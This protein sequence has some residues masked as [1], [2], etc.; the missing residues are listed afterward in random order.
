MKDQKKKENALEEILQKSAVLERLPMEAIF[1]P[2]TMNRLTKAFGY[3]DEDEEEMFVTTW[4]G[5]YEISTGKLTAASAGHEYPIIRKA[6]GDFEVYKDIHGFVLGGM[7]GLKYKEYELHFEKGDMLF[8]Y[9][10]GLPEATNAA[11]D[12]Y[13]LDR[14]VKALNDNKDRS[15]REL[16]DAVKADVDAF[17]GDADQFDDLTMLVLKIE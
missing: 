15:L 2:D 14:A 7:E 4:F 13:E 5:V 11:E 1:T 3:D 16:L 17:V 10:D 9:T 6:G 12:M 8:L